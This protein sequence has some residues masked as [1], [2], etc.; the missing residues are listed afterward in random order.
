[1]PNAAV[2]ISLPLWDYRE[3]NLPKRRGFP[4]L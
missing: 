2:P 4:F 1:M 3:L